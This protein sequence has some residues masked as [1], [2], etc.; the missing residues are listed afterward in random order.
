MEFDFT[1]GPYIKISLVW[2]TPM[3]YNDLLANYQLTTICKIILL[4]KG[5]LCLPYEHTFLNCVV[6]CSERHLMLSLVNVM[7]RV[8]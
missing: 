7:S 5:M 4:V 2:Q 1:E 8:V 3:R 6:Y